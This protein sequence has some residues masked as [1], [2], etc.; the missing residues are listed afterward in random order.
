MSSLY[1]LKMYRILYKI[2]QHRESTKYIRSSTL[3]LNCTFIF[4][5]RF[6]LLRCTYFE[7]GTRGTSSFG[8]SIHFHHT[9]VYVTSTYNESTLK[10]IFL[11]R[12][13]RGTVVKINLIQSRPTIEKYLQHTLQ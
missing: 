7:D 6:I 8:I 9:R 5:F 11:I 3:H 1:F 13:I 4:L 12:Y 10:L 2:I